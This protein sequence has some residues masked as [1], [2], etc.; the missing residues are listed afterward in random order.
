MLHKCFTMGDEVFI[1]G[2]SDRGDLEIYD[3]EKNS[4]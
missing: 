1:F 3:V 4:S 2:G